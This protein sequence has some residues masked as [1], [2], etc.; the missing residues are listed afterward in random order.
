ML[1]DQRKPRALAALALAVAAG[2]ALACGPRAP[3]DAEAE[4]WRARAGRVEILRDEWGVPHVYGESDAD[5]VFGMLYAQAEDDFPRIERNYLVALGRL[6]EAEGEGALWSD[7]RAR[8]FVDERELRALEAAAPEWLRELTA[9]WAEGLNGYLATHPEVRPRVLERFEPWMALAF[10]EGSIGGDLERVDLAALEAFYGDPAA[11]LALVE[12]EAAAAQPAASPEHS[13]GLLESGLARPDP[14]LE[15]SGSNGIAIAPARTRDGHALLLIN[16]H[17]SFFFRHEAQVASREGLNVYGASTWGQPFVYQ[18]FN[19]RAGWMHTSSEV[20]N[21]D[22]FVERIV[23]RGGRLVA[24]DGGSERPVEAREVGLRYR[25]GGRLAERRF[26]MYRTHHGPVVRA[27][28][29]RW[30]SVALM[31]RPVE[32]LAQSFLRT[33]ARSLD[34]YLE[35]LGASA[36]SSNNTIFADADGRIAYLHAEFVPVRDRRFDYDRPVDGS[37]PATAWRGLHPFAERPNVLDPPTGWVV[38]TNDWAYSAAG[39]AGPR[40]AAFPAY[41]DRGSENPRGVHARR[42]LEGASGWTLEGLAAAAFDPWLPAFETLVPLLLADFASLSAQDSNRARCA[43]PL[44]ELADWDR[45]WGVGSVATTLAIVWAEELRARQREAADGKGSDPV[46]WIARPGAGGERRDAFTAALDRLERDFGGWRIAWGEI[47]RYQRLTGDIVQPFDDAAP[48]TP[49]GFVSGR[50]GSL[51]SFGAAPRPGTRR[52]YGT[53]GN[54]FVAVV[55]FGPKV[56]AL[57]VTAGGL[58]GDP[59]SPHFADQV[60]R[61]ASGDLREVHFHREDVEAHARRRYRPGL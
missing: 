31:A 22:E 43:A 24:L 5:A 11:A 18:G 23:E 28:G 50:W 26:T 15:P 60:E 32:Q 36:N 21:V 61:H 6:A 29:G 58:A 19:E 44:A 39:D 27:E 59:A 14:A 12:R 4:R 3:V 25:E 55:E 42:L 47:N 54:S 20:D 48:S 1:R 56:R 40:R 53:S 30:V 9:A 10:T 57:A 34:E 8:L 16:P 45:R 13:A 46:A 7:L 41:V 51:A 49:V 17:T 35:A 52:W 33:K 37:D 2:F 38:N